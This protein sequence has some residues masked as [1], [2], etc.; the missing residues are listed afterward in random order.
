MRRRL[1]LGIAG[2][3]QPTLASSQ[4]MRTLRL[5]VIG[6]LLAISYAYP[7]HDLRVVTVIN[8]NWRIAATDLKKVSAARLKQRFRT[9]RTPTAF[10]GCCDPK[11]KRKRPIC[12]SPHL[13]RDRNHGETLDQ[14]G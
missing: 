10:S 3:P 12:F 2:K 5:K 1:K 14:I 13:Y 9:R 8:N 4:Y 11:R 7:I 6:A